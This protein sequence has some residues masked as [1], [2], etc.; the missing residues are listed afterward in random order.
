MEITAV[1]VIQTLDL[2]EIPLWLP[3]YSPKTEAKA[4]RFVL[5][6]LP[7]LCSW[8]ILIDPAT[9]NECHTLLKNIL[10]SIGVDRPQWVCATPVNTESDDDYS[11]SDLIEKIH[12]VFILSFGVQ[13]EALEKSAAHALFFPETLI[14]CL[15]QPL[16]K[17]QVMYELYR[18]MHLSNA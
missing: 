13:V 3:K 7:P 11:L 6:S 5:S 15:K 14:Q 10:W 8:L 4:S 18:F 2:L 16:I 12:P 9:N 17:Q 1:D